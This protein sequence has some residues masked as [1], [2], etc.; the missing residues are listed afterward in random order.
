MSD[1]KFEY[2]HIEKVE[3]P[4]GPVEVRSAMYGGLVVT[5]NDIKMLRQKL[6][7]EQYYRQQQEEH[8][9][10][11]HAMKIQAASYRST[12]IMWPFLAIPSTILLVLAILNFFH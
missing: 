1:G 3:T 10:L 12:P 7:Q 5:S 11:M 9:L 6:E 4:D 8:E 2:H